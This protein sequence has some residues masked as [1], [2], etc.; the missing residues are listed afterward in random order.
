MQRTTRFQYLRCPAGHGRLIGF[1]DFL[2]E[3]DFIRPLSPAQIDTLRRNLQTVSCSSCGAPIDL[4]RSSACEHCGAP[5]SM[6][7]FEHASQLIA[8]LQGASVAAAPAA[9]SGHAPMIDPALPMRL[10]QARREVATSFA[11]FD[12]DPSWFADVSASNLI[13]AGFRAV[14][15]WMAK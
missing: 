7:D 8:E 6:I 2:R 15:R 9:P 5:L 13:A 10:A 3:K 4:A 14:S 11:A 12:Q 1:L